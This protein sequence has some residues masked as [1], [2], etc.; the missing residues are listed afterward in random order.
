MTGHLISIHSNE[1]QRKLQYILP[2]N[3]YKYLIGLKKDNQD[4]YV[5]SDNTDTNY[6]NFN[7]V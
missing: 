1:E 5:W 6:F 7:A 2:D 4:N 3:N